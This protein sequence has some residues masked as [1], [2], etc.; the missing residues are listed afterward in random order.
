MFHRFGKYLL[1]LFPITTLILVLKYMKIPDELNWL[2]VAFLSI[3]AILDRLNTKIFSSYGYSFSIVVLGLL[4][5]DIFTIAY[6]LVFF[7]FSFLVLWLKRKP[8]FLFVLLPLLSIQ[9]IITVIGNE[10]Y[11]L[12]SEKDY[13]ARYVTLIM[14]LF[15]SVALYYLA[16]AIETGRFSTAILLTIFGPMI[17]EIIVIFP[18]LSAFDK[19]SYPLVIGLFIAYYIVVG[20]LHRNYLDVNEEHVKAL[21]QRLNPRRELEVLFM[22][23]GQ[24]KGVYFA[25]KRMIVIDEK[26]DFPEQFQTL[27]HEWI[28]H[29]LRGKLRL[30]PPVEEILVTFL[31]AIISWYHIATIHR[32]SKNKPKIKE[33]NTQLLEIEGISE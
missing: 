2:L 26:I 23:L 9:L 27:I 15:M 20:I 25:N 6:S 24:Y 7:L 1:L 13:M 17:F 4:I 16:I 10:F 11:N 5:F 32:W 28:H 21:I 33:H 29:K 18:F 22:D 8:N 19:F 14:M 31:E 30:F 12:Y 3:A